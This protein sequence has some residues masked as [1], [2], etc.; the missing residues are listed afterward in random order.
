MKDVV[1]DNRKLV[2]RVGDLEYEL[3]RVKPELAKV[4]GEDAV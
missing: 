3:K 4:K 2:S 1:A